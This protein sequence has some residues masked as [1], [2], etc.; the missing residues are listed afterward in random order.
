MGANDLTAPIEIKADQ[1]WVDRLDARWQVWGIFDGVVELDRI[2]GFQ[3]RSVTPADLRDGHVLE[4]AP[5]A[6]N[7]PAGAYE[8]QAFHPG[9]INESLLPHRTPG[10]TISP[11]FLAELDEPIPYLQPLYD[12]VTEYECREQGCDFEIHAVGPDAAPAYIDE[13]RDEIDAHE[14]KHIGARVGWI[15]DDGTEALAPVSLPIASVPGFVRHT[16]EPCDLR[17]RFSSQAGVA[18]HRYSPT[19]FGTPPRTFGYNLVTI[20]PQGNH[21][22]PRLDGTVTREEAQAELADLAPFMVDGYT[23]VL[24][25]L[26]EVTR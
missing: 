23:T 5:I 2:P 18:A 15:D 25:E 4:V 12:G 21:S 20:D 22:G 17:P 10:T 9:G 26:R 24:V 14:R 13:M 3:H 6:A 11:A 19:R 16:N 8:P 1:I 7:A